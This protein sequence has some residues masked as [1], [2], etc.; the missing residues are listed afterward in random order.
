MANRPPKYCQAYPCP[1]LAGPGSAYCAQHKPARA[2]KDTEPFYLSPAWRRFRI[3]YLRNHPL[4]ELCQAEG[5]NTPAAMVDHV[6]ELKDGGDRLSEANAMSLCW[7]CHGVKTA[8]EKNHRGSLK[9]NRAVS[10]KKSLLR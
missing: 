1:A 7:K 2:P 3:W 8:N 10:V 6:V 9:N 4:C 5:R